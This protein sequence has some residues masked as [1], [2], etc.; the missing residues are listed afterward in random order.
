M[1]ESNGIDFIRLEAI[2]RLRRKSHTVKTPP[3]NTNND[4]KQD[5]YIL[6]LFLFILCVFILFFCY[7]CGA[8]FLF[9]SFFCLQAR[10]ASVPSQ[11]KFKHHMSYKHYINSAEYLRMLI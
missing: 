3:N 8:F 10:S 2:V 6:I 4:S 1:S 5:K 9:L 11:H 7:A